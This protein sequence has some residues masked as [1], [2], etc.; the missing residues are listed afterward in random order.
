MII[1]SAH[2]H[3]FGIYN[4][5][6]HKLQLHNEGNMSLITSTVGFIV[7]ASGKNLTFY[8]SLLE[9][10]PQTILHDAEIIQ[11]IQLSPCS[12]AV[13]DENSMV[14]EY[15]SDGK[16]NRKF[17]KI[18]KDVR[19]GFI[20]HKGSMSPIQ[21]GKCGAIFEDTKIIQNVNLKASD[22][23]TG[24]EH[25]AIINGTQLTFNGSNQ[26]GQIPESNVDNV[27]LFCC[28]GWG[29]AWITQD[30]DF[31]SHGFETDWIDTERIKNII[32]KYNIVHFIGG[33]HFL[34]LASKNDVFWIGPDEYFEMK[35][36][37]EIRS[38]FAS[39]YDCFI[40]CSN[41]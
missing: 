13:L 23:A 6:L 21:I 30:G 24:L 5:P 9:K 3:R 14:F 41:L 7:T 8:H 10:E 2:L 4:N 1:F 32:E 16:R 40:D 31:L 18:E 35:S 15:F 12:V 19:L 37:Q 38:I 36:D 17:L 33:N 34:V 25:F 27:K 39:Q 20:N 28:T 26:R 22:L 11:M 29:T